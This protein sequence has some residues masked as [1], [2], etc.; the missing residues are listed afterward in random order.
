[1]SRSF[2]R[3]LLGGAFLAVAALCLSIG[4]AYLPLSKT[5]AQTSLPAAKATMQLGNINVMDARLGAANTKSNWQ[6]IMSGSMKTS[7]QKD[8]V[9]TASLEVGLY[10]RTLVSSKN[11]VSDTSSAMAGVEVRVVVDAGTPNE[12]IA[13]PGDVVFGRRNQQLTA[14]FQGLIDGCLT[15]DLTTGSVILNQDCVRPETLELVLDTMNASSF[16]FALDDMG[17]GVHTMKVQARMVMNTTVQTGDVEARCTIG[18]GSMAVEE[19]RL[20][21]A[22]DITL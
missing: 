17:S 10:T 5:G 7:Q 22:L 6:T 21:K 16:V 13:Y 20:V 8:L 18:K 15:T 11:G 1:M 3:L 4:S 14:T 12:R 9:M 2:N 19:V